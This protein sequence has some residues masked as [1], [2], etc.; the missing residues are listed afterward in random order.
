[1]ALIALVKDGQAALRS[2]QMPRAT[3]YLSRAERGLIAFL[4]NGPIAA[5]AKAA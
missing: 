4:E 5:P 2:M 3:Q 1:P